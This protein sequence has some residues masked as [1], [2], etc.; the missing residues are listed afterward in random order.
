MNITQQQYEELQAFAETLDPDNPINLSNIL[1]KEELAELHSADDLQKH[2]NLPLFLCKKIW[3]EL[4]NIRAGASTLNR[5]VAIMTKT[6]TKTT[7]TFEKIQFAFESANYTIT[8]DMS[9]FVFGRKKDTNDGIGLP[10]KL[11]SGKH[12]SIKW[13]QEV[14]S[15]V[16]KDE[17]SLNGTYIKSTQTILQSGIL[18]ELGNIIYKSDIDSV[19]KTVKLEVFARKLGDEERSK[20]LEISFNNRTSA[21][22]GNQSGNCEYKIN[23][24]GVS[25]KH[26]EITWTKSQE[27]MLKAYQGEY[28]WIRLSS[29]KKESKHIE[30]PVDLSSKDL[31]VRFCLLY[32]SPSPRDS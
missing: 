9:E 28:F 19:N 3:K 25:S 16:I 8:K 23:D 31:E 18:I 5:N 24:P 17:G 27:P 6:T 32:T 15:F 12:A 14:S 26:V 2:S 13:S 22:I 20:G 1:T 7:Q 10:L 29:Q 30:I 4:E 21:S 11:V